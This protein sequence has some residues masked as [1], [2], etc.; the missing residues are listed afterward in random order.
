MSKY[1]KINSENIVE[2]AIICEDSQISLFDGEWIKVTDSTND[3]HVGY[4]YNRDSNRFIGPKPPFESWVLNSNSIWESPIGPKP[5]DGEYDWNEVEQDWVKC[6]PVNN[7]QPSP[8][9][10]WNEETKIWSIPE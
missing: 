3:A 1:A 5:T 10:I 7:V 2:N 6:I 8:D 9:H 4:P